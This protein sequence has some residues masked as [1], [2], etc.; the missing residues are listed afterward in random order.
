MKY[1]F[2]K[3]TFIAQHEQAD[4]LAISGT[5]GTFTWKEFEVKVSEIIAFFKVH[6]LDQ[7]FNPIIIYG[8]KNAAMLAAMYACMSMNIPYI[9]VDSSY[10][11][12]RVSKI[13]A[14][15]Q[16]NLIINTS[17]ADLKEF[18]TS[19]IVLNQSITI[20][21]RPKPFKSHLSNVLDLV[22]II[23]TSGSTG[24]PKGV[25]ISNEAVQSFTK[26]MSSEDFRFSNKDVF[27]NTALLSFDLSVFE[28]MTF[29]AVGA[30]IVLNAKE[31]TSDQSVLLNKIDKYQGTVWVSTPSF[32][33]LYSR[34]E[35]DERLKSIH[36][37][38]FCG[39]ILPHNLAKTLRIKYNNTKIVNTYGPTEA[40][41]ATTIINITDEILEK[42]NPLPVGKCKMDSE[43]LIVDEE[44]IIVGPNVSVGYINRPDLNMEKFISRDKQRA[45]KTGDKGYLENGLLFFNGRN[46]DMVKL[47]GYRIE[48]NEIT[49]VLHN[50]PYVFQAATVALERGGVVK[51]IVSLVTLKPNEHKTSQE[52]K[53]DLKMT[54]PD[55]MVPADIKLVTEI[56]LN[57]N[58]KADKK[59]LIKLYMGK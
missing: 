39:E 35:E 23:F 40:T 28:V 53:E 25:Q 14:A 12:N 26:W 48:I 16:T 10:P 47:H 24:E 56:P 46:D 52:I 11:T 5:E 49:S 32:A 6:E 18:H 20:V 58:G 8:H 3:K 59:A 33:F 17:S 37:F 15:A 36:T 54:I 4:Q 30:S 1:C 55:Y 7:A 42:Y 41:V 13:I 38:L 51:K 27:I 57:Q 29:A 31:E 9:P 21:N 19:E 44:I 50:L 22:Y 45:F 2:H 43:L 34:L